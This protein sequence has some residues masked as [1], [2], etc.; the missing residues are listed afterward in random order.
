MLIT[1]NTAKYAVAMLPKSVEKFVRSAMHEMYINKRI[2]I[3]VSLASQIHQVPQVGIPH[4]DPVT[5]VMNVKTRP[6]THVD[7]AISANNCI[8]YTMKRK[9]IAAIKTYKPIDIHAE[10]T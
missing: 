10:G 9:D 2:S 5:S 3:D 4:I 7:S 6:T 8:L 1:P